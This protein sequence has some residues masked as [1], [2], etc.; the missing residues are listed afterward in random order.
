MVLVSMLM[1]PT[2]RL[3]AIIDLRRMLVLGRQTIVNRHNHIA[4]LRHFAA[5]Q[6]IKPLIPRYPSPSVN[7]NDGGKPRLMLYVPSRGH[8]DICQ[9]QWVLL[10]AIR[11]VKMDLHPCFSNPTRSLG[12]PLGIRFEFG[13]S[14][15]TRWRLGSRR[16][17]R[18]YHGGLLCLKSPALYQE[19]PS[20]CN[21]PKCISNGSITDAMDAFFIC[22][23]GAPNGVTQE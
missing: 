17:S 3:T 13:F 19:H 4:L 22:L 1:Q 8:V 21:N 10:L 18:R 16:L 23:H 12:K 14:R 11:N 2:Q 9:L 6:R 7:R 20:E 5:M 15:G